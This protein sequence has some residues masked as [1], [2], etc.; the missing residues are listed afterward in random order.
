MSD[1][2]EVWA[3]SRSMRVGWSVLAA[4]CAVAAAAMGVAAGGGSVVEPDPRAAWV[5]GMEAVYQGEVVEEVR[6]PGQQ[7]RRRHH[8][9]VRVVAV[10]GTARW[11]DLAVMTR[12]LRQEDGALRGVGPLL[13]VGGEEEGLPL[14][15]LEWV[16][17][18][19]SG[20]VW[21]LRPEGP[22][23]LRWSEQTP[24][25][26]L[27]PLPLDSFAASELGMF[28]PPRPKGEVQ[29]A[30]T[31]PGR[32]A[33]RWQRMGTEA[34]HGERCVVLRLHQQGDS[35]KGAEA[36]QRQETLWL[37]TQDGVVRRVER[38]IERSSSQQALPWAWVETRYELRT[39]LPVAGRRWERLRRDLEV[40]YCAL[41]DAEELAPQAA[42]LGPRPFEQRLA[43]LE[44][45]LADSDAADPY[46]PL[47]LAGQRALEAARH[48][49]VPTSAI[50]EPRTT[51]HWPH[52]GQPA[53]EISIGNRTLSSWRG[54][55]VLLLFFPAEGETTEL[56]LAIAH[57]LQQRYG[58]QAAI[59]PLVA[60]GPLERAEQ[61]AR[62]RRWNL[63]LY[64]GR[65]AAADYAV[66]TA[67]RFLLLDA[68][69]RVR[70][71]FTGVGAEV[72][73]LVR[74]QLERCLASL[75]SPASP[76]SA[77]TATGTNGPAVPS[78]PPP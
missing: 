70:W 34:V 8:L 57:A 45:C 28:A 66:T 43:R 13:Q 38:R 26:P 78:G 6:R 60:W 29:W 62:R 55:P 64:D 30:R 12:L 61:S 22:P 25:Q 1:G 11:A 2:S 46:R 20:E 39:L 74:D 48:G 33:E 41:R 15:R 75:R 72:G 67:P 7:F 3:V 40:A 37:S 71:S 35:D 73:Y 23:P 56:A 69:G 31:V 5:R 9:E 36:W 4:G 14:L 54:R 18:A 51:P 65:T 32:P 10:D 58:E 50:S 17:L 59:L 42:R 52:D 24:R 47:L 53:P 19:T 44:A 63:T 68:Q 76:S 21:R 27:P 16:R 77:A 49:R